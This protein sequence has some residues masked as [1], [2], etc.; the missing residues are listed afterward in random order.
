MLKPKRFLGSTQFGRQLG[1]QVLKRRLI[2]LSIATVL[3]CGVVVLVLVLV[4]MNTGLYLTPTTQPDFDEVPRN[5]V[6]H[7]AWM[8]QALN[9][10]AAEDMQ[11]LF[12]EGFFFSHI[13]YGLAWVEIGLRSTEH[14]DEA[15]REALWTLSH[16]ES[17]PGKA[18][19]PPELP[20]GYGMFYSGWRNH[21]QAGIVLLTEDQSE[22]ARLRT[23][24]DALVEA[25]TSSTAWPWLA[26]YPNL[27]WPCDAPPGIHAMCVYD[28]VTR[29]GR[30]SDFVERWIVTGRF[31]SSHLWAV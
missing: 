28:E 26:S 1:L 6:S 15:V 18:I 21:L 25:L 16:I 30:Y 13:L 17:D 8:K 11:Q 12:P 10:G 5:A 7:L 3:R 22:L 24:C 20:P 19:F 14:R 31:K 2:P 27:V 9:D 4:W 23:Q 29:E